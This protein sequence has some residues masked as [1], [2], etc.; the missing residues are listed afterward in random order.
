MYNEKTVKPVA[1]RNEIKEFKV[2]LKGKTFKFTY[3]IDALLEIL[4]SNVFT[5]IQIPVYMHNSM[6]FGNDRKG[7]TTV[8]NIVSFNPE[9]G[10][11][12]INIFNKY[13]SKVEDVA[14]AIV[15][16]R[17]V[18]IYD[19]SAERTEDQ[20]AENIKILGFDIA[21]EEFYSNI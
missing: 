16:P 21:S 17:V 18:G 4:T 5:K 11:M 9:E 20:V 15:F 8:G 12:K 14:D 10:T 1:R 13:I 2:F 19:K 7:L 6:L 3:K